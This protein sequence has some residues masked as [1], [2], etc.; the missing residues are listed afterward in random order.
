MEVWRGEDETVPS[1]RIWGGGVAEF[2]LGRREAE[3][4]V[5]VVSFAEGVGVDESGRREK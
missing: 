4:F 1:V 3:L 2:S 5:G